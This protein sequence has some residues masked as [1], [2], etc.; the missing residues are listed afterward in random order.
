MLPLVLA[1]L[2]VAT[3]TTKEVATILKWCFMP[4]PVFSTNI[5]ILNIILRKFLSF[6]YVADKTI[7]V[8]PLN[9]YAPNDRFTNDNVSD[10]L[11][12]FDRLIAMWM[13]LFLFFAI[14]FYWVLLTLVESRIFSFCFRSITGSN[15]GGGATV[16]RQTTEM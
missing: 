14:I 3:D 11:K 2:Q 4:I 9:P 1:I 7:E 16:L 5:G 13:L 8:D 15:N 6:V 12:P 10:G